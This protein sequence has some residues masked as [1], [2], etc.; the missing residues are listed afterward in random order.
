M[1]HAE[2]ASLR[3]G[4]RL[5]VLDTASEDAERL[6]KRLGWVRVGVIPNYALLPDGQFC[7]TTIYWK[8]LS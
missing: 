6:Y 5:L 1:E 4:K 2:A 7:S 3:A 8:W